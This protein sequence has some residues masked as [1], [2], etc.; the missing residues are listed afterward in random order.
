MRPDIHSFKD[1]CIFIRDNKYTWWL[2]YIPAYLIYFAVLENITVPDEAVRIIE[3]P[4]DR[5]IPTIPWF[6]IFYAIWWVLFPGAILYFLIKGTKED[7]LKL[8]FI[9]F[10]GYTVCLFVYTVAPNGLNL[11]EPL[12]GHDIFSVF[13]GWMRAI[14]PPRNVC[15]SMHVSSTVAIDV[16]VRGASYI[17]IRSKNIVTI[18]SILI[19]LSTLFIRQH[20]IIDV[21]CG[22]GMSLVLLFVWNLW[23]KDF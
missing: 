10:G 5:M 17:R 2:L 6:F 3:T 18:I 8:C 21:L 12:T 9:L 7:F 20:S 15:P 4:L 16:T 1:L 19:C 23:H 14:D 22:W 11:R 13:I